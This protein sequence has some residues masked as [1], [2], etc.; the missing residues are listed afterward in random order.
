MG[1]GSISKMIKATSM[2]GF[3]G[4]VGGF[5]EFRAKTIS[6]VCDGHFGNFWT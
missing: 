6:F 2:L 3:K 1:F 5:P 4:I